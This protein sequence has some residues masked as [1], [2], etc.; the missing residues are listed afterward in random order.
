MGVAMQWEWKGKEDKLDKSGILA[1]EF[2]GGKASIELPDFGEAHYL[3]QLIHKEIQAAERRG[4]MNAVARYA[5]LGDEI[6]N[7]A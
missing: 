7:D 6:T 5:R 2:V 3:A 4:A 1:F